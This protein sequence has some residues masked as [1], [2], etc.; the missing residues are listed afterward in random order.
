MS[1]DIEMTRQGALYLWG[2]FFYNSM[3]ESAKCDRRNS[4]EGNPVHPTLCMKQWL[5]YVCMTY[6]WA[7]FSCC[8]FLHNACRCLCFSR[9]APNYPM[10]GLLFLS[11][12]RCPMGLKYLEQSGI[13]L[14]LRQRGFVTSRP[15]WYAFDSLGRQSEQWITVHV[16]ETLLQVLWCDGNQCKTGREVLSSTRLWSSRTCW[17]VGH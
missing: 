6:V 4:E 9:P 13:V 17:N 1:C 12:V 5:H 2:S 3:L 10:V 14:L 16:I 11:A 8:L 15:G 7:S